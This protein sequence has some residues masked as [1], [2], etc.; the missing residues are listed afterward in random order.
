MPSVSTSSELLHILTKSELVDRNVLQQYLN[1]LKEKNTLPNAASD[2]A[3][4]MVQSGLLTQFQAKLLLQGKWKNFFIGNKYKVL[5]HL[6]SGGMGS[7]FLC[8]HK[9]MRRRVAIKILP[10]DKSKNRT[11]LERFR[12][13]AQAVAMLNHVN[14]V[15]AHDIDQDGE[16]HFI[17]MEYIEGVNLYQLV[18]KGGPLSVARAV[19]YTVQSAIGLDHAH[20]HRLVHRDIKPSNLLLDRGGVI[21]ILDLGLARFNCDEYDNHLTMANEKTVL[22]TADYLAPEQARD[23]AGVDIRA[24]IYGLGATLYYM[25][26]GKPMFAG[27]SLAQKLIYH[28][29]TM[30]KPLN[31]L[32]GDVEPKLAEVVQKMLEKDPNNRQKG[33]D[34]LVADLL[35]WFQEVPPPAED[36]LPEHRYSAHR[37]VDTI[38]RLKGDKTLGYDQRTSHH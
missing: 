26:L 5:E 37:D 3:Q 13:E 11:I 1:G 6:G 30:P 10:P 17:V 21:R 25:L 23:A 22:G 8:E 18:E 33:P 29:T 34:R 31:L 38:H 32:R 2:F 14:I 7:V 28:Q 9:H 27:L 36:E 16:M 19:N 35:P 4:L 15:R 24:D 20:Q 12:R